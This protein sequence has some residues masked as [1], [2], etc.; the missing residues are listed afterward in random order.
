MQIICH[1]FSAYDPEKKDDLKD[2]LD[3]EELI[4]T[5]YSIIQRENQDSIRLSA[6]K[7]ID[8]FFYF[9]EE[10]SKVWIE[11][12]QLWHFLLDSERD[13][14]SDKY[15][16]ESIDTHALTLKLCTSCLRR[17]NGPNFIVCNAFY[18]QQ[19]T[20]KRVLFMLE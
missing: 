8:L 18:T 16:G 11:D 4:R 10:F 14:L 9:D 1:L 12:Y 5:L 17:E 2:F 3:R 6:L 15:P 19:A 20:L 13:L 7:V